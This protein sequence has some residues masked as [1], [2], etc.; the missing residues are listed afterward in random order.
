MGNMHSARVLNI[1]LSWAENKSFVFQTCNLRAVFLQ[2]I[3]LTSGV[4]YWKDD[5]NTLEFAR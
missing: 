1:L 2:T 4:W 3:K 5:T